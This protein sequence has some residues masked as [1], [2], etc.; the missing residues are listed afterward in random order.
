KHQI[1]YLK[2][3]IKT[4]EIKILEDSLELLQDKLATEQ[5]M[6]AVYQEEEAMVKANKVIGGQDNGVNVADLKVAVDYYRQRLTDIKTNLLK[7]NKNIKKLNE[8]VYRISAQLQQL[9]AKKNIPT[10]EVIVT[11]STK[12]PV[13]AKMDLSYLVASAG[14]SPTYDLRVEDINKPID[15]Y[16]KANVFQSSGEEWEK[17]KL[18][19]STGNPTLSGAKPVLNAWF[20]DFY[21]HYDV[22]RGRYN[23]MAPM[24]S[25][26]AKA[27]E[28]EVL[29]DDLSSSDSPTYAWQLTQVSESQTNIE[30]KIDAPYDIPS[31]NKTYMVDIQ[32]HT[33]NA[34]FQYYAVPKLDKDA[35]LLARVSGWEEYNL[36]SGNVNLFFEG[37]YVGVSYIDSR[38]TKDTIDFSLGRDKNI[39]VT[40]IRLKE[41]SSKKTI[42]LNQKETIAWEINVRNKKKQDISIV[43]EDQFP[44]SSNKDIEIEQLE[45]SD[46]KYDSDTGILKWEFQ[47]K[48][49]ET[50]KM[51][52]MYSVKYPKN[53][54]VNLN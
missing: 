2:T 22:G 6:L 15:L 45:K 51:K 13:T 26:M 42:G 47:L 31:D 25:E 23:D 35:F 9:N 29:A 24:R 10:S 19:L 44:I 36:L 41:F 38:S 52:L 8:D 46:A 50:K 30:F 34:S 21:Q 17:V 43:I 4:K 18:T 49:A 5:G 39:V 3:Q 14:W 33:L 20:L 27:E 53:Q 28:R 48:P 40:R 7:V 16:Y 37:T 1:N 54:V 11:V 12:A 32:K